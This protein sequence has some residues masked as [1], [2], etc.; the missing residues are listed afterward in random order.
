MRKKIVQIGANRGNDDL[1]KIINDEQPEILILVEPMI[2]HNEILKK[3]YQWISNLHIENVIISDKSSEYIDFFYHLDDGPGFEVA[4]LDINHIIKHYRERTDRIVKINLKSMNINDLFN[5]YNLSDIDV[6]FI[7]AEGIDDLI[8]K[9]IDF[10]KIKISK[11]YFENLHL[12]DI[13]IY[14]YL[15]ELGYNITMKTGS[16]GWCSLAE[17]LH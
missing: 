15:R 3:N 9:S 6:L 4:S 13:K 7:D 17:K 14:D 16:Y 8:I 2:L 1:T 5:K 12:K 11:I 10:S